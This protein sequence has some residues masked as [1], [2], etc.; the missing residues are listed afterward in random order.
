MRLRRLEPVLRRALDG[1]IRARPGSSVLVAVS[2]GA[3]STALL[4]GLHALAGERG[5]ELHAAH[6][7]HGLR[8][9]DAD[10]DREFVAGLCARLGVPLVSARWDTRRRMR[11][12][13][14]SGEGGLRVLRREFL[15]R[16]A[17]RVGATLIA[18]AHTADDQLETV[19]LRLGRGSGLP[20]L[21]A[22][23]PRAGRWIKPLLEA[24]RADV[25]ADLRRIGQAW[26]EDRSNHDLRLARN[27]VRHEVVPALARAVTPQAGPERARTMLA[28]RAA[29]TAAEARAAERAIRVLLEPVLARSVRSRGEDLTIDLAGVR[30]PLA[31]RLALYRRAWRHFPQPGPGLTARHL[32]SL[33]RLAL[34]GRP[35]SSVALP[36]GRTA[37]RDR[38]SICLRPGRIQ[39]DVA[40]AEP[41]KVLTARLPVPGSA[42]AAGCRVVGRWITGG[43]AIGRLPKKGPSEEYFAA[44]E[45][46]AAL[47]LRPANADEAFVPFGRRRPVRLGEFMRE[48]RAPL[49]QRERP[50]VLADASGILWVVGV[51]R[52]AR[53]PVVPNTRRVLWVQAERH[54]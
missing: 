27:R 20:G 19:L 48:Q 13:G 16:A 26:R 54:D 10:R 24:T 22:M 51:R 53:A 25:E 8:G 15:A 47:E 11:S 37:L 50:T 17:R 12:R 40:A 9:G 35:G 45:I 6:L 18:T 41:V 34:R 43:R 42:V 29:R 2:G 7:H 21:G 30:L 46:G 23:H 36:D 33:D 52:S 4:V 31:V 1:P 14:L 3:D 32:E 5:I 39:P 44:G 28:R 49:A 38:S